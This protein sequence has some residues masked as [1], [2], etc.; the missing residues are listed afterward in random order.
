MRPFTALLW[1]LV[2]LAV[3]SETGH[4]GDASRSLAVVCRLRG[5]F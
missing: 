3:Q 5:N 4:F 2:R 1:T